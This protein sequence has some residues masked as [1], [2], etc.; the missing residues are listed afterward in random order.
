M[1]GSHSAAEAHSQKK[2]VQAPSPVGTKPGGASSATR[3]G[4]ARKSTAI[5]S[6][7]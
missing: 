6:P 4:S 7:E 2:N 3:A 1:R 5:T